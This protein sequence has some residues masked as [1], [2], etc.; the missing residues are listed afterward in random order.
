MSREQEVQSFFERPEI[1][2]HFDYNLKIRG[3]NVMSF[4]GDQKFQKA[5]DM[6]CGNGIISTL[7]IDQTEK[8]TC[9]D[10]SSKMVEL[11]RQNIPEEKHE[12]VTFIN[13]DFYNQS[14]EE[15]SYDLVVCLGILAHIKDPIGYVKAVGELVKPGGKFIL[16]NTN[17][18]HFYAKLI[19]L[20]LGFRKLVGKDKYAL[21]KVRSK[22]ILSAVRVDFNV[23]KQFKYNQSFLGFSRLFS[24]ERKYKLTRK[25]FGT[26]DVP[27]KQSFGCDNTWLFEK[28]S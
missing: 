4:I 15:E 5:I 12:K 2:L 7:I 8:L 21:N 16:Q 14:F 27:K 23:V 3:E 6:P 9:I 24:N 13:D 22:D 26:V 18:G 25:W 19:R 17:H 1:Y 11:T 10:F 28:K 20:Y